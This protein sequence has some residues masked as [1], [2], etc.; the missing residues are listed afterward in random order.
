MRLSSRF[1][2]L[3]AALAVAA[4]A[5][6]ACSGQPV[7]TPSG[8]PPTSTPAPAT[9]RPT[10][11]VTAAPTPESGLD[12]TLVSDGPVLEGSDLEEGDHYGATLPA[13]YFTVDGVHHL[14]VVGIRRHSR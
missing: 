6:A 11:A 14:Y 8:A 9:S 12:I 4:L 13:T 7:V 1:Q 2:I 5:M 3:L 10:P